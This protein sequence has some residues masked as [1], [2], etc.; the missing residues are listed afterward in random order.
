[1]FSIF[2]ACQ[3]VG[4]ELDPFSCTKV[5]RGAR[6]RA[7]Q[8]GQAATESDTAKWRALVR[9]SML[10]RK[11][12]ELDGPGAKARA[13]KKQAKVP[14]MATWE[15]LF[16]LDSSMFDT[17][18]HGLEWYTPKVVGRTFDEDFEQEDVDDDNLL[19]MC[20]DEEQTQLAGYY[21]LERKLHLSCVRLQP[22]L[23]RRHNDMMNALVKANMYQ[24]AALTVMQRNISY[25]PWGKG[26]NLQELWEAA[27]EMMQLVKPNDPFSCGCGAASAGT[28]IG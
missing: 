17:L 16:A 12:T 7:A 9:R 24:V 21:Y 1:M 15:W 13:A 6:M 20:A 8:L 19:V 27:V 2:G 4:Y 26:A 14:K 10:K 5:L 25:G 3:A 23:H 28:G 22:P 11:A 18:G